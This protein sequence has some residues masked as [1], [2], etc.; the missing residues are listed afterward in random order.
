[1]EQAKLPVSGLHPTSF[2]SLSTSEL[3]EREQ[4]LIQLQ[5][6]L[7]A[8]RQA[9]NQQAQMLAEQEQQ[10]LSRGNPFAV[11]SR[12]HGRQLEQ[13]AQREQ[14][15]AQER[16]SLDDRY[17]ELQ[18]L[19]QSMPGKEEQYETFRKRARQDK[20]VNRY[21]RLLQEVLDNCDDCRWSGDEVDEFLEQAESIKDKVVSFCKAHQIDERRLLIYQGLVFI[22]SEVEEEQ[23]EQT[24][25]LFSGSSVDFDYGPEYQAKIKAFMVQT[26]D[27]EVPASST[28]VESGVKTEVNDEDD[29][30]EEEDDDDE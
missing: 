26:F 8:D 6:K 13:L 19:L 20:L 16:L 12:E 21:N 25:G 15:L 30:W 11:T 1:M 7:E 23:E 10:I 14:A 18:R 9:L 4:Q 28:P 24:T 22:I 27:Q 3:A 2:S 5:T 29:E 17:A